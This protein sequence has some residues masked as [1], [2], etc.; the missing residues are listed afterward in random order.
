M[1]MR[2]VKLI[3]GVIWPVL[4]YYLISAAVSMAVSKCLPE[5]FLAEPDRAAL[6]VTISA[7]CCLA[8]F[9]VMLHRDGEMCIV[10]RFGDLAYFFAGALIALGS[11]FLMR[12]VFPEGMENGGIQQQLL[13]S[14]LP[15]QI[16]GPGLLVPLAEEVLYRGLL[17]GRIRRAC[18]A[19]AAIILTAVLFAIGHGSRVQI[20]Y[21]L[22]CG[23]VL[24]LARE[25]SGGLA[26]PVL[27]HAGANLTAVWMTYLLAAR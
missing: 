6:T 25:K 1:S 17:F 3:S 8:V 15:L 12:M 26:A 2:N 16:L 11:S 10:P 18:P 14:S 27:F 24:G 9:P 21:A 23:V 7:V 22:I 13:Q 5:R 20:L 4:L 19:A